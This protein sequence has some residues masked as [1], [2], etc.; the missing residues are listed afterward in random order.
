LEWCGRWAGPNMRPGRPPRSI[1]RRG[2]AWGILAHFPHS[3]SQHSKWWLCISTGEHEDSSGEQDCR[4]ASGNEDADA[5]ASVNFTVLKRQLGN[6]A[7]CSGIRDSSAGL[8]QRLLSRGDAAIRVIRKVLA[9]V[10]WVNLPFIGRFGFNSRKGAEAQRLRSLDFLCVFASLREKKRRCGLPSRW[11]GGPLRRQAKRLP[12]NLPQH[13]HLA[14][15]AAKLKTGRRWDSPA[16][17]V[18]DHRLASALAARSAGT[19]SKREGTIEYSARPLD[20]DRIAFA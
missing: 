16:R 17:F 9:G 13:C 5:L 4:G 10:G 14:D 1:R 19:I 7:V 3:S 20:R 18:F 6:C 12:Y 15:R 2:C 11:R 8:R